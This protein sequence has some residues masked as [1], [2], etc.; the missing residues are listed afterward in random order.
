MFM[1]FSYKILILTATVIL[2][3]SPAI[4]LAQSIGFGGEG[5]GTV[6]IIASRGFFNT[7]SSITSAS[8]LDNTFGQLIAIVLGFLA[9]L[10]LALIV[11]SGIQWMTAGGN[12]EKVE[13]AKKRILNASLGL[14]LIFFSYI[15]T[16]IIFNFLEKQS[17]QGQPALPNAQYECQNNADCADSLKPL[18][19]TF[20]TADGEAKWCTC[21]RDRGPACPEGK[22]CNEN[23]G[24]RNQCE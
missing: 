8:F 15:I 7:N 13:S 1:K 11:Y 9:T 6:N 22:T 4:L 14:G 23:I 12:E 20:M 21:F 2:S 24:G 19:E 3:L 5:G 18:C 16:A 17:G 10:F